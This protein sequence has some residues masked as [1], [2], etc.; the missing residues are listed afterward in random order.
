MAKAKSKAR[1]GTARKADP[2]KWWREARF[3]L[4]IHWGLYAVPAGYYKGQDCPGIGEWIMYRFQIPV[5]EYE[6][7]AR[8][9]NPVKFNAEQWVRLAKEAGMKYIVITSKHHDGFAM[10]DSPSNDYDIVDATPYGKD[11]MAA[12]A[13]ACK[14]HG[15]RLCFYYSQYQD[16]HHPNGGR[17]SWDFDE[18]AKDFEQ[19][20]R[21][22]CFPQLRELL[23][24]YGPIGLIWFDTPGKMTRSQSMR[25]RRLVHK[26]QPRC[27]VSGRVG[28]DVGDYASMGDNQ[29]PAGRV[30][31]DW[32]TPATMNDTWGFKK[33]DRNWKSVRTLLHLLCDL[34]SKGVNYL[35]NVGPTAEGL[36]PAASVKRLKAIGQWMK[37]NGEAIYGTEANPYPYELEWGRITQK[38]GRLYLLMY[39]WPRRLTLLGL[40]N[41]V[42]KAYLLADRRKAVQVTQCHD[43]AVDQHA[44]ELKL[45]AGKPDKNVSV[46]VL[47]IAGT[48][49][50]DESP[51]QQPGG[52]ISLPAHLAELHTPKAGRKIQIGRGGVIENWFTRSNWIRWGFKV[53]RPGEFELRV[54]TSVRGRKWEG[55]HEVKVTLGRRCITK[56]IRADE[57][58]E[59]PRTLHAPEAATNF[60]RVTIARPGTHTLTLRAERIKKT[61]RAGLGIASVQ[62]V[63][64][65]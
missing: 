5:A 35:L 56:T 6:Q 12:L 10:Y 43:K 41:K 55:G 11:V 7:Y 65:E 25:C 39:K 38:R 28:N 23:T 13:R 42:K 21:D 34:A 9:L 54:V 33:Q 61:A 63:P 20:L 50:V 52:A 59:S 49:D 14:K 40:R 44:L 64:V 16:W 27:L 58:L 46:I 3:G 45:P 4:F 22:K 29:I 17:N 36:I 53:S 8:Q 19:Y 62:L 2:L 26:L 30:A 32:E 60:G 31:G 37:V 57:M 47:E 18:D 51:L 15:L 1:G 24:Q 48:A